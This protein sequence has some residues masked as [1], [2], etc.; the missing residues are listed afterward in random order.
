MKKIILFSSFMLS[1][2]L[3]AIGQRTCGQEEYHQNLIQSEPGYLNRIQ[4]IEQSTESFI[5]DN[6]TEGNRTV[7]TIPVVFHIV[8][9]TTSQNI[10]DSKIIEQINQLN[11]DYTAMNTDNGNTPSIFQPTGNMGIQF[12]LASRDPNGFPTTGIERRQTTVTSFG[13][14]SAVK[15]YST[16]GLDPWPNSSYLNIW[17]CNLSNGILGFATF[18]GATAA[19]DGVVLLYSSIGSVSSPGLSSVYGLGRTAT[20]EVGHWLNLRHIWGDAT[21]GTDNVTDT[22]SHNAANYGCPTYPHYSTCTGTPVEMTMNY[23]DYTD[24]ACMYMFSAGQALRSQALFAVGGARASLLNSSGCIPP[25]SSTCGTPTSLTTSNPT[26][27]SV[28]VAWTSVYAANSYTLQ[29]K[30]SNSSTWASV[31][32]SSLS[33]NLTGLLAGTSYN[34]QVRAECGTNSGNF[35]SSSFTTSSQS[36]TCTDNYEANNS[37]SKAKLIPVNTSITGLISTS[38]DKDW[39]TFSNTTA[40]PNIRIDLTNLPAN[41]N[42]RLYTSGGAQVGTSENLGTTSEVIIYNTTTIASWKIQVFGSGGAFNATSCYNLLVS[43]SNN[44]FR[45]EVQISDEEFV[46]FSVFPNPVENSIKINFKTNKIENYEI[47]IIDNIGRNVFTQKYVSNTGVNQI[48]IDMSDI[49][50]GLYNLVLVADDRR[51]NIKLIKH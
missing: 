46:D 11:L 40:T 30:P 6:N 35:I 50:Y 16:G 9:N 28:T 22:P 21:C 47:F 17:V 38:T 27:N 44:N 19:T 37:S 12:C 29:Y 34:I 2:L 39:F 45:E 49:S 1:M 3:G 7:I 14:N 23:M 32:V 26:T 13:T 18:P 43:L 33:Y 31:S 25:S 5:R 15:A 41:Y 10:S 42:V 8:W 4:Q 48:E 20:H 51:Q 24:D 36:S